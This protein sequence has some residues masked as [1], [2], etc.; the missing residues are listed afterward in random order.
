M[1]IDPVSS[2]VFEAESSEDRVML[3]RPR[4]PKSPLLSF[5]LIAGTLLQGGIVLFVTM[6]VYVTS[7]GRDIPETEARALAFVTLVV[8]NFALIFTNRAT[9]FAIVDLVRR[10]NLILWGVVAVTTAILLIVLFTPALR[11]IFFFGPLH[12]DD[13][14]LCAVAGVTAFTVLELTKWVGGKLGHHDA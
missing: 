5:W 4:D 12:G 7:L 1:V 8:A 2:I 6:V 13:L 10:P 3:R 14:I 11:S 9:G